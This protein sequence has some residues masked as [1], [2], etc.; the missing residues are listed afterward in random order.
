MLK[1]NVLTSFKDQWL[2]SFRGNV[3][4]SLFNYFCMT[5]L[6]FKHYLLLI[7]SYAYI[8][9]ETHMLNKTPFCYG[10]LYFRHRCDCKEGYELKKN[11]RTCRGEEQCAVVNTTDSFINFLFYYINYYWV[12]FYHL[13]LH[14]IVVRTPSYPFFCMSCLI[15]FSLFS[16]IHLFIF[17]SF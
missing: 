10:F 4:W 2:W 13:L 14:W 16:C 6:W 8:Y 5:S 11:G 7:T 9:V 1:L 15:F 17:H 12:I 3:N